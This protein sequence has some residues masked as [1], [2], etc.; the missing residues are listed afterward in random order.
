MRQLLARFLSDQTGATSIEYSMIAVCI[1]VA[2]ITTVR[3]LGVTVTDS[4]VS[5]AN[6]LK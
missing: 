1:A 2:V 4:Y 5:V 3:S 6:L